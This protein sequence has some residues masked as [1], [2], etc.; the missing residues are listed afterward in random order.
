[1]T[2]SQEPQNDTEVLLLLKEGQEAA[3]EIIYRKYSM[4]VFTYILRIVKRQDLQ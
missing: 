4:R 1:M 3:F 2:A